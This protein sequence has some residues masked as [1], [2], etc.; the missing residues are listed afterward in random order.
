[1]QDLTKDLAQRFG[2]ETDEGVLVTRVA[3]GS[4]AEM[5]GIQAGS[6]IQEVDRKPVKNIQEFHDAIK[7][8]ES[9]R[10]MLLLVKEGAFSRY[11]VLQWEDHAPTK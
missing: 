5:A 3:S 8:E 11:V 9:E 1:M 4:L 2:Y 6:L 10:S 7:K